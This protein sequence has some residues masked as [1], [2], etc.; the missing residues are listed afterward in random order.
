MTSYRSIGRVAR[1]ALVAACAAALL[2]P[3]AAGAGRAKTHTVEI[4]SDYYDPGTLTVRK[5]D[6]VRFKWIEGLE[7]HNVTVDKGPKEFHSPLKGSGTWTKRMTTP[8][9]YTLVCTIHDMTM[10]LVVKR[11]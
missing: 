6:R 5:N 10:K 9:R 4:G 11:R 2:V 3:A 7:V 8:G 1:V